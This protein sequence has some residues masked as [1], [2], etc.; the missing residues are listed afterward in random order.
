MGA[1]GDSFYE[2][3]LKA[4]VQTNQEDVEAREMFDEAL[5]SMFTY[6]YKTSRG[7]LSYFA[8]LKFESVEHKMDHLACFSGWYQIYCNFSAAPVINSSE[9]F[10]M[11]FVFTGGLLALAAKT[12]QDEFTEKYKDA[13]AA[14]TNTCHESYDR[15]AVKLGPEVFRFT[16][17]MEAMALRANEKYYILRPEVVESYFVLWRTTKDPKYREWGWEAVQVGA[18][19]WM[20]LWHTSFV[21]CVDSNIFHLFCLAGS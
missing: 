14:I 10:C 1:L 12:K 3:L 20:S 2:Y 8:D 9:P 6:M 7:G 15:S 21:H 13:A 19:C 11:Y 5:N 4:W 17:S 18:I 16:E